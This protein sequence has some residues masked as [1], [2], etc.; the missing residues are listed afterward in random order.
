MPECPWLE[1]SRMPGHLQCLDGSFCGEV[2]PNNYS[3]CCQGV[4]RARCPPDFPYMCNLQTC[5]VQHCC[6][7]FAHD[8]I[9]HAEGLR[10]CD[11]GTEVAQHCPWISD[12]GV[13]N[14]ILCSDG[15][16]CEAIGGA[17]FS[18]CCTYLQRHQ[19]SPE[20]PHMCMDAICAEQHCCTDVA[21][22]CDY[23]AGGLRTCP[24]FTG[25]MHIWCPWTTHTNE[26]GH[27][28]C[29]D[30]SLCEQTDNGDYGHCCVDMGRARCPPEYPHMCNDMACHGQ[31][32]CTDQGGMCEDYGGGLRPCPDDTHL[33]IDLAL[34][35]VYC[36]WVS[37]S[38]VPNH[39]QCMNGT[40]CDYSDC[41]QGDAR[42][43]C[44]PEFPYMC[45]DPECGGQH[46]CTAEADHCEILGGM[47]SC[48]DV[49]A[50]DM[51]PETA[52]IAS[53]SRGACA[54]WAFLVV[55]T[56]PASWSML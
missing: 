44:P 41:C 51:D 14:H 9:D 7:E 16:L 35:A 21:A 3:D 36:P 54:A 8:C 56:L 2:A 4:G 1:S 50:D 19:C 53:G 27:I 46:C 31:H 38:G 29:A 48:E 18:H 13:S 47:R 43:R 12:T 39:L 40:M 34:V 33:S 23:G 42:A 49:L 52:L 6:A 32:C 5:S 10:G 17:D 25:E 11:N 20:F 30:G 37:S 15:R 22:N 45:A 26:P 24:D 55:L 28:Q